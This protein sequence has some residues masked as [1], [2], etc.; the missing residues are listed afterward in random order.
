MYLFKILSTEDL[1]PSQYWVVETGT[2]EQFKTDMADVNLPI[3]SNMLVFTGNTAE[4]F[5]I[6]D[7]YRPY[8]QADIRCSIAVNK[9]CVPNYV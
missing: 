7:V 1:K 9:K 3:D 5:E 4:Y 8:P 2:L 6:F